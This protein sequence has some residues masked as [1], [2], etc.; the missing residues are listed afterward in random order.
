M[1]FALHLLALGVGT[2]MFLGMMILHRRARASQQ[3]ARAMGAADPADSGFVRRPTV[4][5]AIH[6]TDAAAVQAVLGP[7]YPKLCPRAGGLPGGRELHIGPPLN[8]WIIVTGPGIPHPGSDVDRCFLFLTQLSRALGHVQFFM[9]DPILLHH[10]W[11]RVDNGVVTRAYAWAD[12]TVWNQGAKTIAEIELNMKCFSYGEDTGM[13][14]AILKE[15]AAANV[16]KIPSLSARWNFDPSVAGG[17]LQNPAGGGTG[18]VSWFFK[19]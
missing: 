19:D 14:G 9:A 5:L 16:E 17:N 4:W 2:I 12:G 3:M 6:S 7:A 13:A 8:N 1:L 18:R 10:A 15:N 11:A